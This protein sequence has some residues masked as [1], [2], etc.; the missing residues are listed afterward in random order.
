MRETGRR[1]FDCGTP[2]GKIR[3]LPD[4]PLHLAGYAMNRKTAVWTLVAAL[5][6]LFAF[7][8]VSFDPRFSA[9]GEQRE[10]DPAEEA[11]Y[12]AC[13]EA[14]DKAIHREAFGT[15]DNPDV[16]KLFITNQRAAAAAAC[17]EEFPEQ[18]ITVDEPLQFNLF[19]LRFRY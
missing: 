18:W 1:D 11:R 10:L 7:F 15:I 6:V 5:A 16:Q 13:Y 14:R 9:G 2:G 12:A 3:V 17:R 8:D 19:D 4:A